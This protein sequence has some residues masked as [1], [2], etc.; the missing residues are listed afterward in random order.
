MA[1]PFVQGRLR[2]EML[3]VDISTE[4]AHCGQPLHLAVDSEMRHQVSEVGAAPLV[5]QPLIDWGTFSEPNIID[6]F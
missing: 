4:C 2:K 5:F 6:A 1:T 3:S